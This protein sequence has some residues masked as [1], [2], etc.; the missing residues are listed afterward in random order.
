MTIRDDGWSEDG[1][2]DVVGEDD[3]SAPAPTP[4]SDAASTAASPPRNAS[5]SRPVRP[6][7][8]IAD[9]RSRR[10]CAFPDLGRWRPIVV[11]D[12]GWAWSMLARSGEPGS[13]KPVA[14]TRHG[15]HRSAPH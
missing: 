7:E 14:R 8:A 10:S 2:Q 9:V 13:V 5:S 11:V 4:T 15:R 3:R 6:Q 1:W 12:G